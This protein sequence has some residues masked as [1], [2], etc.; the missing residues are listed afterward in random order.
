MVKSEENALINKISQLTEKTVL[1]DKYDADI[2]AM[3]N[4][5]GMFE[6]LEKMRYR[7]SGFVYHLSDITLDNLYFSGLTYKYDDKSVVLRGESFSK[8]G[9]PEI[10]VNDFVKNLEK[11][12]FEVHLKGTQKTIQNVYSAAAFDIDMKIDTAVVVKNEQAN[13]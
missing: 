11:E 12:Y 2:N 10:F 1:Y 7:L 6:Q 3:D 4:K 8:D 13:E 9:Y 5:I